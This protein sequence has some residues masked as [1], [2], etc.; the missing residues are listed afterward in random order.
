MARPPC[1]V[2]AESHAHPTALVIRSSLRDNTKDFNQGG[3]CRV[4]CTPNGLSY[5]Y[6]ITKGFNLDMCVP[7]RGHTPRP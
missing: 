2:C 5:P 3:V 4:V 7:S 6:G 1:Y